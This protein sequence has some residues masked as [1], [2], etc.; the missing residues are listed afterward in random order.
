MKEMTEQERLTAAEWHEKRAAWCEKQL[1]VAAWGSERLSA[2]R[3]AV[4]AEKRVAAA[5]RSGEC[6]W[7]VLEQLRAS[8]EPS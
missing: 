5:Y 7:S 4:D 6:R 1:S 8:S 2:L 3:M